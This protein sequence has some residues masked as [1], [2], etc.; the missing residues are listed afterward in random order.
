MASNPE[1]KTAPWHDAQEI[2][3]KLRKALGGD[4]EFWPLWKP[5]FDR[6]KKT[7]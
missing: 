6:V 2:D 3:T 1:P 7:S 4:D 5:Y